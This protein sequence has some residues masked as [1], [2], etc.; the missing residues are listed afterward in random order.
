MSAVIGTHISVRQRDQTEGP[1]SPG[2][3]HLRSVPGGVS[4]SVRHPVGG[5]LR[6]RDL[7]R[8]HG[9]GA[10]VGTHCGGY[11]RVIRAGLASF[12]H[13]YCIIDATEWISIG[14]LRHSN[15]RHCEEM[16]A[17]PSAPEASVCGERLDMGDSARH[18]QLKIRIYRGI[19]L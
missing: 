18:S 10:S 2:I 1:G 7:H 3:S 9:D 19:W 14:D 13:D 15:Q 16:Q 6:E 11:H 4:W 5:R 8:A 17:N 12:V